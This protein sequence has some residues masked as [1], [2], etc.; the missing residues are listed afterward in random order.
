MLECAVENVWK[1]LG[2]LG[3]MNQTVPVRG[4]PVRDGEVRETS[5]PVF[6]LKVFRGWG[7][8]VDPVLNV[9]VD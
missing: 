9:L 5:G 7:A 4:A 8:F 1:R 6:Y 3:L 2:P